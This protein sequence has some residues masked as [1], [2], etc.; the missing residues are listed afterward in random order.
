MEAVKGFPRTIRVEAAERCMLLAGSQD[1]IM[2]MLLAKNKCVE[3]GVIRSCQKFR[4]CD[5]PP[6]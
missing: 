1:P 4:Q 2:S 6:Y 5:S 3:G